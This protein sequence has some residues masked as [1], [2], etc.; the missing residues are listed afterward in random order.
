[1]T[2]R[3]DR[4]GIINDVTTRDDVTS[5]R[6]LAGADARLRFALDA[7]E[8]GYWEID[9]RTGRAE[10]SPLLDRI[11]GLETP[12]PAWSYDT[13][14]TYVHPDDRAAVDRASHHALDTRTEW[15]VECRIVRADGT[16]RWIW[17]R[18]AV[19]DEVDGVPTQMVGVVIDVTRRKDA[20]A[21]R[22]AFLSSVSHDLKTPLTSIVGYAQLARRRLG[23]LGGAGNAGGAE[24]AAVATT[25]RGIEAAAARMRALV[26]DLLEL[27]RAQWGAALPLEPRPTDLAALVRR[28]VGELHVPET[29]RVEVEAPDALRV[30][31]DPDRIERVV[32]NLLSNALTYSPAGGTIRVR[33]ASAPHADGRTDAADAGDAHAVVSVRDA[34]VGIPADELPRIF[35]RFHRGR[36]VVGRIA[37]TGVGLASARQIATAHGGTLDVESAEG[38]GSTFTLRLPLRS[39]RPRPGPPVPPKTPRSPTPAADRTPETTP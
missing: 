31:I 39:P 4:C 3:G 20:D 8:V 15:E 12:L 2:T 10:R 33:V 7:A 18:G 35:E 23:R 19:S 28:L 38:V 27:T 26:D 25:I 34:G 37:G 14:L 32:G 30:E 5:A 36:N 21:E 11:F 6:T 1:V 22:E 9:L 13:F 24:V 16:P 17:S 29:H